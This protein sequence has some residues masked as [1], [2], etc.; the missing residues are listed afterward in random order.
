MIELTRRTIE[1]ISERSIVLSSSDSLLRSFAERM[2]GGRSSAV[3]DQSIANELSD[4][5]CSV[6]LVRIAGNEGQ[7]YTDRYSEL[8]RERSRIC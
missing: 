1:R 2:S 6:Y 7:R 5:S 3:V 4:D 8:I